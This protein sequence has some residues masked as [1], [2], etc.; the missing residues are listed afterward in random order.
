MQ[1]DKLQQVVYST[2]FVALHDL[3][4]EPKSTKITV[5]AAR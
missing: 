2:A 4:H 3:Q 1:K 5:R